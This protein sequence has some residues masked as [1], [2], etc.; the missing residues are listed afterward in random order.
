[1]QKFDALIRRLREYNAWWYGED[2]EQPDPAQVGVDIGSA[3]LAIEEMQGAIVR[4]LG[5]NR[6]LA[7][8]DDCTL[9]HLVGLGLVE[10]A[11]NDDV[12]YPVPKTQFCGWIEE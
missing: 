9:R 11:Q 7:D 1:M 3:A 8:G 2:T 10:Q 5:E 6:R 4:T 12:P